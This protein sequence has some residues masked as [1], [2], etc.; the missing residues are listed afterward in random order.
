MSHHTIRDTTPPR[1]SLTPASDSAARVIAAGMAALDGKLEAKGLD[2]VMARICTAVQNAY[3]T[4]AAAEMD[5]GVD[6]RDLLRA[7]E[8]A[9]GCL[10]AQAITASLQGAPGV[11]Q[12]IALS[13][14]AHVATHFAMATI[15]AR[16]A[17]DKSF[18]IEEQVPVERAGAA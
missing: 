14:V 13:S 16:S 3:L 1:P 5:G 2:G 6:K 11:I 10:M 9:V 7:S 18:C 17:G 4:A 8:R 12:Q 15:E